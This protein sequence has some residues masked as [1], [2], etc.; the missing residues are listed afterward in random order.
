MTM[1]HPHAAEQYPTLD[2]WTT[3]PWLFYFYDFVGC[4]VGTEVF[5]CTYALEEPGI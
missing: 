4:V 2:M 3:I 5:V 1:L